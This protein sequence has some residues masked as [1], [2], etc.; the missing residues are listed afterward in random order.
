MFRTYLSSANEEEQD[1]ERVVVRKDF[2]KAIIEGYLE[3]MKDLMTSYE[4][5]SL[6]Y[7]GEFMIYMQALR[8]MTDYINDDI[9][10]GTTYELNNYNRAINQL[11]LLQQYQ[12][13]S[14]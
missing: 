12:S 4:L 6:I 10:Y 5:Q 3:T 14:N 9:Y 8:F 13:L 7:A 11:K 1:F 2:F